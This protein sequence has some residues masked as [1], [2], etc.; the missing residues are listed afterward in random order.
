M[1][2]LFV[3][4]AVFISSQAFAKVGKK[5]V[6]PTQPG[7][8]C[9]ETAEAAAQATA[10]AK[11]ASTDELKKITTESLDP[12]NGVLYKVTVGSSVFYVITGSTD[13][14]CWIETIKA[15]E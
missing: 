14:A 15:I 10:K 5:A 3:V 12:E 2:N 6:D 13:S 9:G 8:F 7:M 11:G 1:K 4:I